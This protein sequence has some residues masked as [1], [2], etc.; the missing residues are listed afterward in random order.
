MSDIVNNQNTKIFGFTLLGQQIKVVDSE[1]PKTQSHTQVLSFVE[2]EGL[3]NVTGLSSRNRVR[4]SASTAFA[5]S[6]KQSNF[7]RYNQPI[8]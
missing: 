5:S 4:V 1:F 2:Y 6:G 8:A 7:D 3:H